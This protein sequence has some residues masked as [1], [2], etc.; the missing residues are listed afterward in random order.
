MKG[1]IGW[2]I[3]YWWVVPFFMVL[4]MLVILFVMFQIPGGWVEDMSI[5]VWLVAAIAELVLLVLLLFHKEW[6]RLFLSM[7]I[8]VGIVVVLPFISLIAMSAPDGF[9]R[10]HPIPEGM[11]LNIPLGD[12]EATIDSNNVDSFLQIWNGDQGGIYEYDFYYPQLSAG[13]IFLRC[14]EAGKNE[15]LSEDRL[16][17]SS[18]VENT[19]VMEFSKVVEKQKFT[20]YEGDWEEYYAVRVEVWHRDSISCKETKLMEKFYR[21]EGWMR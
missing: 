11:E 5:V 17:K 19:A 13:T 9:A 3:N 21:M 7:A 4:Q 12:G 1:V 15:P 6:K 18:A 10:H 16:L 20:I 14:F 2:I 8:V